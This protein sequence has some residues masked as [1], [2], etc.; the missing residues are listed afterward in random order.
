MSFITDYV[1]K[2]TC[3]VTLSNNN[4]NSHRNVLKKILCSLKKKM[5][6]VF[7]VFIIIFSEVRRFG[8]AELMSL[9]CW[10][11]E[12]IMVSPAWVKAP[13]RAKGMEAWM[14]CVGP[15][16][17]FGAVRCWVE[18]QQPGER[19]SDFTAATLVSWISSLFYERNH[20]RRFLFVLSCIRV[21]NVWSS[22]CVCA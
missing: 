8:S 20:M 2:D 4:N 14:T 13:L 3:G 17:R 1:I 10:P 6:T 16:S 15:S 12:V 18:A 5:R 22:A 9:V 7:E 11:V 19:S 21:V